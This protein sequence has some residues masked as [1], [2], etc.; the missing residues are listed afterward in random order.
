[1]PADSIGGRALV[2]VIAIMTFL[3]SLTTGA[4]IMMHASAADWQSEIA[5][6]ITIQC[7]RS[8]KAMRRPKFRKRRDRAGIPRIAEV[9]L[10]RKEESARLLSPGSAPVLALDDL[11]V[12]RVIVLK[13]APGPAPDLTDCASSCPNA[14]QA[15]A[16]M[17]IAASSSACARWPI[18]PSPAAS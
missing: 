14:S 13:L 16:S 5:R 1:V 6:E 8:A 10:I 7:A 15:Q 2:A 11:P 9:R 18:P 4:V 12:P 3:A 17:I